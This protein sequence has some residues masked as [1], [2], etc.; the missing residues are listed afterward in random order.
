MI[1]STMPVHAWRSVAAL[2]AITAAG[3]ANVADADRDRP[4][5]PPVA[6]PQ[7]PQRAEPRPPAHTAPAAPERAICVLVP[8][9]GSGVEGMLELRRDGDRITLSGEITGLTPGLHGFHVHEFGDLRDR[10]QG[11]SAGDHFS[12]DG[13]P[14]GRP[15]D[16]ERHTGDLG[17]IEANEDGVA[18]VE[19]TDLRIAFDG[20]HSVIGRALVVH[21]DPDRFTQPAGD[22][23]DRVAVGV[24]GIANPGFRGGDR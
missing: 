5:S 13:K 4:N 9:G 2:L 6:A 24:I 1:H 19:V 11:K 17:N 22:A 21:A 3:C 23:G 20:P 10:E 7:D 16:D 15:E 18:K 12:P 8:I 14:H